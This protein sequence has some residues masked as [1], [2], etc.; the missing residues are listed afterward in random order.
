MKTIQVPRLGFLAKYY[1]DKT[2]SF[3]PDYR[4]CGKVFYTWEE[5][6]KHLCAS[7]KEEYEVLKPQFVELWAQREASEQKEK[8]RERL[9]R[10]PKVIEAIEDTRFKCPRCHQYRSNGFIVRYPSGKVAKLCTRCE[11]R[12]RLG[13]KNI[14]QKMITV[15]FETS[16]KKH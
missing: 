2:A 8:E 14:V 3:Q 10:P 1:N 5:L 9:S 6:E 12:I 15:P 4:C 11:A 7:H 13:R 16:K